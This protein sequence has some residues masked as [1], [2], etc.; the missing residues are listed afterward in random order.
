MATCKAYVFRKRLVFWPSVSPNPLVLRGVEKSWTSGSS[1]STRKARTCCSRTSV[2]PGTAWPVANST[3]LNIGDHGLIVIEAW[4]NGDNK[5]NVR[6]QAIF[7]MLQQ[8]KLLISRQNYLMD[9]VFALRRAAISWK[10]RA[11]RPL[12]TPFGRSLKSSSIE[13]LVFINGADDDQLYHLPPVLKA[14]FRKRYQTRA[15]GLRLKIS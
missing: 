3:P 11:S 15:A 5:Q 10:K 12:E 7:F 1:R 6:S 9:R 4:A 14:T 8:R 13:H 2:P